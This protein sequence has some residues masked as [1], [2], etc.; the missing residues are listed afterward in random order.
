MLANPHCANQTLGA[1]LP[2]QLHMNAFRVCLCL[3]LVV[4]SVWLYAP[5][6]AQNAFTDYDDIRHVL[7][8]LT[9][10]LPTEFKSPD[11]SASR[12]VWPQWVKAHDRDI[13]AR[14]QRGDEDTIVNWLLFGTSF[15]QQPMALF[16]ISVTSD[17]WRGVISQRARDLISVLAA[18]DKNDRSVFASQVLQSQGYRFDTA[19]ERARLESHLQAQVERVLAERQEYR[20]REDGFP[21]GDVIGQV[22]VEST[23]FRDRGVSL[24]TSILSSFAVDQ[25][26]ETMK[27]QQLLMPHSVRRVAVIGPGLD[28]ADKNSG[29]DFYPAQ[30]M[31]PFTTIDS[32]VRLGLAAEPA[33][34]ELTALDISPRVNDHINAFRDRAK[35]GNPYVLR[36]PTDLGSRWTPALVSYWKSIGNRIGSETPISK[37]PDRIRGID[38]RGIAVRPQIAA[39][40]TPVDFNVVTE[41]WQGPQFDLIIATNVFVYYDRLDQAL[42]FAG[43]EAMLRPG[44]FFITNNVIVEL[45]VSRLRSVGLMKVQHSAEKIDHVFWYRRNQG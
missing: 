39:G 42:A 22:M 31:Q 37:P 25:A 24:D 41:N 7:A 5:A 30:T 13:R 3:T 4:C 33:Q 20:L 16:E 44:G 32:L 21:T 19:K 26:L 18:A 45:P 38:F 8:Y 28:F 34:I 27:S 2:L 11:L 17:S 6:L 10:I 36:L 15:T 23:L 29:Y 1:R 43:I 9:D 40:V 35:T 14:L 12:E